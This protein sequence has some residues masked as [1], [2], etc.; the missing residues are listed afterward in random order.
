MEEF[1]ENIDMDNLRN[2]ICNDSDYGDETDMALTV[3]QEKMS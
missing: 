2:T 1:L 3:N